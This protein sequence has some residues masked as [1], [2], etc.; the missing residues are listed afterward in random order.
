M[1]H[2]VLILDGVPS[3]VTVL[4]D[5]EVYQAVVDHHPSFNLILERLNSDPH[6]ESVVDLFDVERTLVRAFEQVTERI[7]IR[8][9]QVFFD[10]DRLHNGVEK[11]ILRFVDEGQMDRLDAVVNFTEKVMTNPQEHSR[12]QLFTWLDRHDFTITQDG[13]FVG[14][15]G[16]HAS[17]EGPRSTRVAP[18]K[19]GVVR[20]GAPVSGEKVLN[21]AGDVIEMP[22]SRVDFNAGVGCSTGLHVGT[23]AYA[24]SFA[25]ELLEVHVNP[26]DVVS[27]PTDCDAQKIRTCRYTVIGPIEQEYATAVLPRAQVEVDVEDEDDEFY[28]GEYEDEYDDE[29]YDE[30]VEEAE[31]ELEVAINN[32]ADAVQAVRDTRHN[33]LTQKRYPKGHPKAGRFIP[34]DSPDYNLY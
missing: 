29:D 34:K 22:R 7:S 20:N 26:R 19:D 14:Y 17:D 28:Y 8:N 32:L 33:H 1:K 31:Q 4:V 18:D 11:Q 10:G 15:K 25:S 9:G 30:S 27:V 6:D 16:C 5:G 21:L 2:T 24:S 13:D 23:Y 3:V 12:D